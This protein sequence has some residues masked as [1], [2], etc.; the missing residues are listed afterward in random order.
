MWGISYF[1]YTSLVILGGKVV[2]IVMNVF[3]HIFVSLPN[4]FQWLQNFITLYN[5]LR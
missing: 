3:S 2:C 4:I 1:M 5:L